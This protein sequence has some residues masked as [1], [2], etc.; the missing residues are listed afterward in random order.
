MS[1]FAKSGY[2]SREKYLEARRRGQRRYY[3]KTAKYP[4]QEWTEEED[5]AVLAHAVPDRT[6][7][8]ILGRSMHSIQNRR[9]RLNKER[10]DD[11]QNER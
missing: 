9:C 7:S 10:R 2:K 6:L 11:A 3:A 1:G 5:A 8:E 4:R